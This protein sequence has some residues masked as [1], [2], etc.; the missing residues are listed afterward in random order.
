MGQAGSR[1][2]LTRAVHS[3]DGLQSMP[4]AEIDFCIVFSTPSWAY[5]SEAL[6]SE[7]AIECDEIDRGER[8]R[9]HCT[10]SWRR[11]AVNTRVDSKGRRVQSWWCPGIAH[12]VHARQRNLEN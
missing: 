1:C 4:D 3:R 8:R 2:L 10:I 7:E 5:T 11:V 6:G 9:H 12:A